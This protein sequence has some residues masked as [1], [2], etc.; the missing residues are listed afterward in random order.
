ML[1]LEPVKDKTDINSNLYLVKLSET[2]YKL[3]MPDENT[4]VLPEPP[5]QGYAIKWP[6]NPYFTGR[7]AIADIIEHMDILK[8]SQIFY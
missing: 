5:K 8:G 4:G 1:N 7:S 2:T 6:V 3:I